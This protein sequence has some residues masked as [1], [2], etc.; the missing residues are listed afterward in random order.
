MIDVDSLFGDIWSGLAAPGD[1]SWRDNDAQED[2]AKHDS[3]TCR[4]K[5]FNS[6]EF[7]LRF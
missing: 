5:R 3:K 4:F 6:F 1:Y 7:V 2:H